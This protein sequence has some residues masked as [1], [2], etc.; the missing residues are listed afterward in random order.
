MDT[1]TF[2]RFVFDW[3]L[4]G[5][6][7][8]EGAEEEDD[9]VLLVPDWSNLH[10]EPDRRP[11]VEDTSHQSGDQRN[12]SWVKTSRSDAGLERCEIENLKEE[13]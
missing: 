11:C 2:G 1:P 8:T 12:A 3:L 4:E 7:V 10:Q 5:S 13:K 6:D 9:L